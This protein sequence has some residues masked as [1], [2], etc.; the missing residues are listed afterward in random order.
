LV[1]CLLLIA[2]LGCRSLAGRPRAAE[3][4]RVPRVLADGDAQRTASLRLLIQGLEADRSGR[5]Q[6]AQGSYERAIQVDPTNPYAYLVLARHDV[7]RAR[8]DA[9]LDLLG[10][11]AALLESEG[12]IEDGVRVHLIGLHGRVLYLQGRGEEA[13][14][15][16]ERARAL[17]PGVWGDGYLDA[18]ELL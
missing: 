4:F 13:D 17:A 15:Y 11:A 9:A 16:L 5:T 12:P 3:P 10:Q 2:P 14:S 8:P 7:E 1:G 18:D 6:R